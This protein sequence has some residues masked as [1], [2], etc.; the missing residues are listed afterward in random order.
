MWT[1][2]VQI[3]PDGLRMDVEQIDD[4][5]LGPALLVILIDA[6]NTFLTPFA[7]GVSGLAFAWRVVSVSLSVCLTASVPESNCIRMNAYSC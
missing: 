5:F 3:T 7:A 4:V 1:S 6:L 2:N